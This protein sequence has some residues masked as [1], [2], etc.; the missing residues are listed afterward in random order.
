M[1]LAEMSQAL[2]EGRKKRGLGMYIDI[3][4]ARTQLLTSA[5][6]PIAE[7]TDRQP[8]GG[9]TLT[10][11]PFNS[12][13]WRNRVTSVLKEASRKPDDP[14]ANR[15]WHG[16]MRYS[17]MSHWGRSYLYDNKTRSILGWQE[18]QTFKVDGEHNL[19]FDYDVLE[20]SWRK[21]EDKVAPK[22]ASVE[23]AN[24]SPDT[25]TAIN[26]ILTITNAL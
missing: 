11:Y 7:I 25:K 19:A 15:Y 5:G 26:E 18:P 12:T 24:I 21:D 22:V 1:R 2:I 16:N 20:N 6:R 3:D 23:I 10:V 14:S 17:A 4:P 13:W 8:D 9:Y